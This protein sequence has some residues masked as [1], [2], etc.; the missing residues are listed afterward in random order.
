L[1]YFGFSF[2]DYFHIRFSTRVSGEMKDNIFTIVFTL[3]KIIKVL[4]AFLDDI[5][6]VMEPIFSSI[7]S[8]VVFTG[9]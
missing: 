2:L 8:A 5:I 6:E 7:V 3:N 9:F 1:V 4:L